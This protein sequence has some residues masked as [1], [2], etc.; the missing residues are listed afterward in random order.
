MLYQRTIHIQLYIV[1]QSQS[2]DCGEPYV[3]VGG[4]LKNVI[5]ILA[6]GLEG[7]LYVTLGMMRN[8]LL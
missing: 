1:D 6:G 3:E 5:A 7:V 8:R 4:A 2:R